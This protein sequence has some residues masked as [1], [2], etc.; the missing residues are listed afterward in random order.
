MISCDVMLKAFLRED[1]A[2][3]I[4]VAN[5]DTRSQGKEGFFAVIIINR[6]ISYDQQDHYKGIMS[7][8]EGGLNKKITTSKCDNQSHH[9]IHGYCDNHDN[10]GYP[11]QHGGHKGV[12]RIFK[13]A[14]LVIGRH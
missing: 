9:D 10:Y 7:Q 3:I 1:T 13:I 8:R 12:I 6:V 4:A 11:T 2:G 5:Q 14:V